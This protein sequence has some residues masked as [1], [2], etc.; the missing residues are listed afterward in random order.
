MPNQIRNSFCT[1]NLA[2]CSPAMPL[3]GAVRAPIN[4]APWAARDEES[5]SELLDKF[6]ESS[7][8]ESIF[9]D[10]SKLN[11]WAIR[12]VRARG[13]EFSRP[14]TR[15]FRGANSSPGRPDRLGAILGPEFG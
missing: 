14:L 7:Q 5:A 4:S 11:P 10:C 1:A 12:L 3:G 9:V 6:L 2:A 15:M 8:R 13:F